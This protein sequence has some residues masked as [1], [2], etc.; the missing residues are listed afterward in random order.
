M[1][2][3]IIVTIG[4]QFGSGGRE[5]GQ[6]LAEMLGIAY[7][8]KELMAMAAKD[9]GLCEEFFE[10]ADERVSGNLS[11]AFSLGYSYMGAYAPFNDI[12]SNDGLFKLQSDT[13]RSLAEKQSCVMVGRC[14]DYILRNEPS[15]VSVFIHNTAENRINRIMEYDKVTEQEAKDR[16]ASIDKS[17]S[18]Y[19]NYYTGK[20]WGHSASYDLCI[21]SSLLGLE[22]TEKFIVTFIKKRFDIE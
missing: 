7:Y 21:N 3:K 19:Y 5:I 6:K 15:C 4:R 10:K 18:S 13:I 12:L 2:N 20:K 22:E 14:A 16:M 1:E 8:D 9:S 11:Y 17:R